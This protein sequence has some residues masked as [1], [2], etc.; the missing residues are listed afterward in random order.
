MSSTSRRNRKPKK[1]SKKKVYYN[2]KVGLYYGF[3]KELRHWVKFDVETHVWDIS[4]PPLLYK[5]QCKLVSDFERASLLP[6]VVNHGTSWS[7]EVRKLLKAIEILK[8]HFYNTDWPKIKNRDWDRD[9]Y[10][11]EMWGIFREGYAV[12]LKHNRVESAGCYEPKR[13]D[14]DTYWRKLDP[15]CDMDVVAEHRVFLK[16][17]LVALLFPDEFSEVLRLYECWRWSRCKDERE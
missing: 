11:N 15:E 8:Q 3:I 14:E 7:G 4:E 16:Q 6:I 9:G 1:P 12:D 5:Q 2:E 10:P 13:A 17:H